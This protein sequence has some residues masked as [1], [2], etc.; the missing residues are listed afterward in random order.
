MKTVVDG[1]RVGLSSLGDLDPASIA[2]VDVLRGPEAV[3]MYGEDAIDGVI[4]IFTKRGYADDGRAMEGASP[5][6]RVA[7]W[8]RQSAT[9]L[10]SVT[11]GL[12]LQGT[13]AIRYN[14]DASTLQSLSATFIVTQYVGHCS[15]TA[16]LTVYDGN[17][18]DAE[19]DSPDLGRALPTAG[20]HG[21]YAVTVNSGISRSDL[22]SSR[23]RV[24][25]H[26]AGHDCAVHFYVRLTGNFGPDHA[27]A[28][29]ESPLLE[30][31]ATT[32][33]AEFLY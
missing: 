32:R 4:R 7:R 10:L 2:H 28:A 14:Q 19:L 13:P 16:S 30:L 27:A 31:S 26:P 8:L 15:G 1:V 29:M 25:Y 21:P 17:V 20:A 9:I 24:T 5:R 3:A 12:R 22:M 18:V 6:P 23:V 11:V 33:I